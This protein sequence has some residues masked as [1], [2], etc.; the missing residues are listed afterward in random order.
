MTILFLSKVNEYVT[1][2]EGLQKDVTID[3]V[4]QL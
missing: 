4:L 2:N 1:R 3:F